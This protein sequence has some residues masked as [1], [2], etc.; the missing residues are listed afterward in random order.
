[1]GEVR[2]LVYSGDVDSCVP[3]LGTEQCVRS[4]QLPIDEPWKSWTVVDAQNYTQIAGK[5]QT[6]AD[7]ALTFA[8]VR[9]CLCVCVRARSMSVR[10]TLL[11][12]QG[13]GHMVPTNQ[14]LPALELFTRFLAGQPL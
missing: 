10:L 6:Y 12:C 1:V 5:V 4:L 2:I 8:T 7:G 9:V 3:Y 11:L 13:A 14:P